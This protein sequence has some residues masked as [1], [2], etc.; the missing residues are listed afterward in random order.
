MG[1]VANKSFMPLLAGMW[2]NFADVES[3]KIRP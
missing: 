1:E 3:G 2:K